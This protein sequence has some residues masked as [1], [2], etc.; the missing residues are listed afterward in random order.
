MKPRHTIPASNPTRS[1][2]FDGRERSYLLHLPPQY[3]PTRRWPIILALHGATS[4]ARLMQLFCGLS[5]KADQAGFVVVYP[6]GSGGLPN[7]LTWNAGGCCGYAVNH[8]INDVGF[9]DHL[10]DDVARHVSV[11]PARVYVAGM[12]N[13]AQMAYRLAAELTHRF[14]AIAAVAGPT[15]IS[16]PRPSRP[17]PV[18]HLHGTDDQFAP[19]LGGVGTRSL[20]KIPFISIE[21]T[22]RMWVR[23]NGCPETPTTTYDPLQVDDGTRI[24]RH[25]FGPGE[26]GSEVLWVIVE[27]GGHTWPGRPPLPE[28]L[29]KSTSNLYANDLIWEFFQKH[30]IRDGGRTFHEKGSM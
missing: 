4:N 8:G 21:E 15:G 5:D 18:V 23:L 9:I 12:S 2:S 10:L 28:A 24:I 26:G 13:G 6:N 3:D 27:G 30:S 7:V 22:V 17:I 1:F 19:F 29:G 16:D 11:D 25:H 20:Y 14:A